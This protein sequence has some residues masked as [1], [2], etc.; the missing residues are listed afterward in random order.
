MYQT[1]EHMEDGAADEG[2][3]A[4]LPPNQPHTPAVEAAP[5]TKED[6]A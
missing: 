3:L 2:K 5:S 6:K 1:S 4:H